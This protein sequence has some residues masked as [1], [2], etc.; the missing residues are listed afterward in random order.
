MGRTRADPVATDP[1]AVCPV[2]SGEPTRRPVPADPPGRVGQPVNDTEPGAFHPL[3]NKLCHPVP[4]RQAQN[5]PGILVEHDH[6]DLTAV[7]GVD[8][9]GCVDQ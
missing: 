3:D 1:V 4:T 7:P 9:A 2:G 5:L 8:R 6:L